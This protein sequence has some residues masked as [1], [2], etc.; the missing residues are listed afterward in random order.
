M[1]AG[2][3]DREEEEGQRY[4]EELGRLELR[5]IRPVLEHLRS[6]DAIHDMNSDQTRS[7]H[8]RLS[9]PSWPLGTWIQPKIVKTVH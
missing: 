2:L 7:I 8:L 6:D 9:R 3:S 1:L 5:A 4:A